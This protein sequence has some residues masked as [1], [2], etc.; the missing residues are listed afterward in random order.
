[1]NTIYNILCN[2]SCFSSCLH[3]DTE[4]KR[5]TFSNGTFQLC[6][7]Y[8]R[9]GEGQREQRRGEGKRGRGEEGVGEEGNRGGEVGRRGE[10]EGKKGLGGKDM[11][12]GSEGKGVICF[13]VPPPPPIFYHVQY[14]CI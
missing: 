10:E 5:Y 4:I 12:V 8:M 13:M 3:F 2:V 1:M 11:C 9:R 7:I 14:V 6:I